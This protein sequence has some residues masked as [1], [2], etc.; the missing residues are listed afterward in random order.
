ME[1]LVVVICVLSLLL[2]AALGAGAV[3]FLKNYLDKQMAHL[4]ERLNGLSAQGALL[5]E[6]LEQ[7]KN[8]PQLLSF[9]AKHI[10]RI[11]APA[12]KNDI[13]KREAEEIPLDE[14]MRIPIISGVNV[15]ME[16]EN[17]SFPID[18]ITYGQKD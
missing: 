12:R 9:I 18:I 3:F 14:N 1:V 5:K 4:E 17:E 11:E 2:L 6:T 16:N 7:H 13:E 10:A 15:R 8:D